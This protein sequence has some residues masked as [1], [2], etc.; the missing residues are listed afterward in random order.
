MATYSEYRRTMVRRFWMYQHDTFPEWQYYF[1][2]PFHSDGRPPVFL[3]KAAGC[4]V[5]INP[6]KNAPERELV[7]NEI[8]PKERH[9]WFQSMSSS[10][11]V[12]QSIL[13]NLKVHDRLHYLAELT[14]DSG[15]PLM[16]DAT[17]SRDKFYME[18]DINHLNEPRPTSVDAFVAGEYRVAI[19]CKLMER[20]VGPCSRPRLTSKHSN[21][22]RD[23][24]NGTYTY[25][26]GRQ[27]RCSLTNIGV[28]YWQYVSDLFTWDSEVDHR[29]C[30]LR[31]TYQLA[32]NILAACVRDDGTIVPDAGHVVLLYDARNPA[33]QDEGQ[34][35]E[36]YDTTRDALHDSRLLRKC[37]WQRIVGHLRK[38]GDFPWLVD[39][40]EIKYGL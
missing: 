28:A 36:A 8:S 26:N 25:Q 15:L 31:K 13:G 6:A 18:Y 2:R 5:L 40:L 19:E 35:D 11:A 39:Q 10:Q 24:C 14:D 17:L 1:E 38:K 30:P 9:R 16:G 21:F 12:A 27:T 4:N 33:F 3:K 23:Y 32:R 34:G 20:E 7:L 29:P 22:E 37:S